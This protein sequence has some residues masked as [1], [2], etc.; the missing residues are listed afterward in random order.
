MGLRR[1]RSRAPSWKWQ[2]DSS[3]TVGSIELKNQIVRF[4]V[5]ITQ[6]TIFHLNLKG[7]VHWPCRFVEQPDWARQWPSVTEGVSGWSGRA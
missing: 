7:E 1:K 3:K 2:G 6:L 4:R 5:K